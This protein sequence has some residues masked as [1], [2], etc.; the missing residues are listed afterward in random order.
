MEKKAPEALDSKELTFVLT[1]LQRIANPPERIF[2]CILSLMGIFGGIACIGMAI[3]ASNVVEALTTVSIG[4][5]IIL[6]F[7][8]IFGRILTSLFL[9]LVSDEYINYLNID[10]RTMTASWGIANEW[11]VGSP[12]SLLTAS[13]G[14]FGT[15]IIRD[16][17]KG[18]SCVIP[19]ES[20]TYDE[21]KRL[22][23][24]QTLEDGRG[25]YK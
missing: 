24:K 14:L 10:V 23:G 9:N 5:V 15:F 22:V 7:Y 8:F 17:A 21:L 20:I 19:K 2:F 25:A 6:I 16:H 3:F 1:K 4:V 11:L 12:L 18:Y 13:K